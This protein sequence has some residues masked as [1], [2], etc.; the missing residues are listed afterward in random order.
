MILSVF[1]NG[2]SMASKA[3]VPTV[4]RDMQYFLVLRTS[5]PAVYTT[6]TACKPTRKSDVTHVLTL[7]IK[8]EITGWVDLLLILVYIAGIL[9]IFGYG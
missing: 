6:K 5:P 4:I 9:Y 8:V 1:P 3:M 7:P 2:V